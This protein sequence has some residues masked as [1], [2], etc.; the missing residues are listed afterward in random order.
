MQADPL[1]R[2]K[3]PTSHGLGRAFHD[4]V[5]V[6]IETAAGGGPLFSMASIVAAIAAR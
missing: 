6:W 2:I 1:F 4:G 3:I 5:N